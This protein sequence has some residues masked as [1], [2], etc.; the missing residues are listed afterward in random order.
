[1]EKFAVLIRLF[2]LQAVFYLFYYDDFPDKYREIWTP[3]AM[4]LLGAWPMVTEE[5]YFEFIQNHLLMYSTIL[6][7]TVFTI[8]WY[9]G[10]LALQRYKAEHHVLE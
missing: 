8:I 9:V 6:A 1:M 4:G 5:M 10:G 3:I 7:L 2:Q